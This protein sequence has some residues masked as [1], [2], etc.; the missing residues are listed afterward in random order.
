M[1]WFVNI[2][3][4]ATADFGG[5]IGRDEEQRGVRFLASTFQG[6]ERAITRGDAIQG[7]LALKVSSEEAQLSSFTF[8]L[9]CS[10]G[11]ISTLADEE[12]D[13]SRYR[14]TEFEETLYRKYAELSSTASEVAELYRQSQQQPADARLWQ[15]VLH[16]L[17]QLQADR[18]WMDHLMLALMEE[19]RRRLS[20]QTPERSTGL[21]TDINR[22]ELINAVT[23]VARDTPEPELRWKMEEL[24]GKLLAMP[25]EQAKESAPE[26]LSEFA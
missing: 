10:N 20:G 11:M 23:A 5:I 24:G 3:K 12:E 18:R 6:I 4:Q 8:R 22:F 13:F 25:V 14:E 26:F 9:V 2:F 1:E 7:G 15:Y 19:R 17:G 21:N 16:S